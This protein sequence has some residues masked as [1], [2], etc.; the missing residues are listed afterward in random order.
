[1]FVHSAVY[2]DLFACG[3]RKEGLEGLESD[4]DILWARF[5]ATGLSEVI[6]IDCSRASYKG[7]NL[8]CGNARRDWVRALRQ[9]NGFQLE[10]GS[11][12]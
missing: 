8:V 2:R 9:P 7:E 3:A 1:M 5:D 11:G 10:T 4:A 12:G 6:A